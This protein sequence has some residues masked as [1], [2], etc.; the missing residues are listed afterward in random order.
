MTSAKVRPTPYT[1][2]LGTFSIAI[3]ERT[4]GASARAYADLLLAGALVANPGNR[5]L[6]RIE[7]SNGRDAAN[8]GH[9]SPML[10]LEGGNP[11][12]Q[13]QVYAC[14]Y[15]SAKPCGQFNGLPMLLFLAMHGPATR[16]NT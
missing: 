4:G 15:A 6:M 8:P 11:L 7:V 9:P 10:S 5:A 3:A 2:T 14:W 1:S 12:I 16:S 13:R